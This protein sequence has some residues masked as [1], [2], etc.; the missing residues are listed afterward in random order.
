[1]SVVVSGDT[2]I[3]VVLGDTE[4][5]I[6]SVGVQGP[7][8]VRGPAGEAGVVSG[9]SPIVYND[10]SK[11]VSFSGGLSVLSD[12]DLSGLSLND[13]LRYNG[14]VFRPVRITA[15]ME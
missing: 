1:M 12:V 4:I 11:S 14:S 9:V 13:L 3:V 10:V 2:E 5:Q 7:P 6:V 8:G 15:D